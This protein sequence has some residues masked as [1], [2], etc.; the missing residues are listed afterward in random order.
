MRRSRAF[1]IATVTILLFALLAVPAAGALTREDQLEHERKADE[2]LK[3]AAAAEKVAADLSVEIESLE[4]RMNTLEDELAAI[5]SEVVQATER[6]RRLRAEVEALRDRVQEKQAAIAQ[7]QAEHDHQADLLAARI[8]ES[9]K[10]GDL[11]FLELLLGSQDLEDFIARTSLA[12]RVMR[13]N[14]DTALELKATT[15]ALGKAKDEL[16][17]SLESVETKRAEAAAAE[18]QLKKLRARQSANLASQEALQSEKEALFKANKKEA[19]RLR[20]L[21]EAEQAESARIAAEL[22]GRGSGIYNGIMAWPVPGFYRVSSGF[23]YRIHPIFGV[24]RMHT[25]IDIGRN[26]NP[27]KSIDGASIVAASA[28]MVVSAG[29]RDGYGN[30]VVIDH[31]NGV[32]T[33]YAHQPSGGIKVSVGQRVGKGDRIGT[34]GSTGYSTGPHLHFEVRV[35]GN[36]VDPMKY[37]R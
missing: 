4:Q 8:Q 27:P 18:S 16:S 13:R 1:L 12:Q 26:L 34:V 22:A 10:Q 29:W 37:L 20:A 23:G 6:T 30:T 21:A 5:S 32:A 9:Y 24:R 19:A 3:A 25:G 31:G 35:N 11:F 7:T 14:L 15:V 2:A 28:G 17:R 36:P 33:L